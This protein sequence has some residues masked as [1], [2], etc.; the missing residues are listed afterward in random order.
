[1]DYEDELQQMQEDA[2]K[3][4]DEE[5][6]DTD[7]D[8]TGYEEESIDTPDNDGEDGEDGDDFEEDGRENESDIE[9]NKREDAESFDEEDENVDEDD[10]DTTSGKD[11][12]TE[13]SDAS[14][15]PVEVEINGQQ[16]TLDSQEE[17]LAYV[18]NKGSGV[19]KRQRKSHID[20]IAEQGDI[21]KDDL[22]LFIDA[23]NGDPAA[24]ARIAQKAKVDLYD[25]NDEQA[26]EYSPK[27]QERLM[28]E[29]DEV[30]A[31]IM[32][33]TALHTDFT[34]VVA[35]VPDSFK[36]TIA[37]NPKALTNFSKHV[38]SGLAQ[39]VIPMV[40]KEQA[41]HGGDFMDLY[42]KIGREVSAAKKD[43]KENKKVRKVDPRAEKLRKQAKNPK[44]SNKGTKTKQTGDDIWNMSTEDFAK[45]YM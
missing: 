41:L 37:S 7:T 45:K 32:E 36:A 27:F 38:K 26:S 12:D 30:A 5:T 29:V 25:L 39:E 31:D 19:S 44:G 6:I 24:I 15:E 2:L 11:S 21:S 23:K 4:L 10:D 34:K 17:L 35:T 42:A 22:K 20:Q 3:E 43:P 9:R 1:M 18:K 16:V 14:F 13:K 28:T 33:D 40:I 8:D